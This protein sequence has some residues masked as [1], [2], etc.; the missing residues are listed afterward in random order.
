MANKWFDSKKVDIIS[1]A[2]AAKQE[3]FFL[4]ELNEG[5]LVFPK[6]SLT[7]FNNAGMNGIM[8]GSIYTIA[9]RSGSGKTTFVNQIESDLLNPILNPKCYQDIIILN[10]NFE[11]AARRLI[12]RKIAREFSKTT[13]QLY[14]A[15]P[16]GN[17]TKDDLEEINNWLQGT[18]ADLPVF[19]VEASANVTQMQAAIFELRDR[20][21]DKKFFITLDHTILV[22]KLGPQ[23][24]LDA[25]YDVVAMFNDAK[26]LIPS[27]Y[28]ILSQLNR[29]I[30]R[31]ERRDKS[32]MHYP[33]KGDIFGGDA[34]FQA[35]DVVGVLHKPADLNIREYGPQGLPSAGKIFM[36]YL[37]TRDGVPF[38]AQLTDDLA[39]SQISEI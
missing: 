11:M 29:D 13:K 24:S 10:F 34:S 19:Y 21:P 5:K 38:I 6:T 30:E 12:G 35:S 3:Y 22:K 16:E 37:K 4:K 33:I 17:I 15:A 27:S 2:E 1:I 26:K 9:G 8:W 32:S 39:F 25:L 28:I 18:I 31:P 23:S 7:K 36:H 20:F 14:Q